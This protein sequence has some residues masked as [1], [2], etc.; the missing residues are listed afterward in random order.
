MKLAAIALVAALAG[1]AASIY[2]SPYQSCTRALEA[3][4]LEKG[5][6]P[7]AAAADAALYCAHYLK[8]N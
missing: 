3:E 5:D 4:N 8:T 7:V 1:W 6:K 2:W